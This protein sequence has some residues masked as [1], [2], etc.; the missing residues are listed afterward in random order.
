MDEVLAFIK[1]KDHEIIHL[2]NELSIGKENYVNSLKD[3]EVKNQEISTLNKILTEERK[4]L[5]E[6]ES[7]VEKLRS[8]R[9]PFQECG[10][11]ME[12]SAPPSRPPRT[13]SMVISAAT[14]VM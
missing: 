14:Q 12:S 4:I 9:I 7:E 11:V 5:L 3:L 1:V 10:V 8:F 13:K 6:K 2:S